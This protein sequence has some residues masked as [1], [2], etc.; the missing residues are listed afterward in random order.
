MCIVKLH[1][2]H[3]IINDMVSHV[4]FDDTRAQK[5]AVLGCLVYELRCYYEAITRLNQVQW[6]QAKGRAVIREIC[7]FWVNTSSV[8]ADSFVSRNT[9][10]AVFVHVQCQTAHVPP[11]H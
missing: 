1:K 10:M 6:T 8:L 7:G 11:Y 5:I 2:S 3:H 9:I 4:Q